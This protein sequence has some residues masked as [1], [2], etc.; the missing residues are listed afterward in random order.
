M[1]YLLLQSDARR[2]PMADRS[3]DLVLGSPPYCDARSYGIG[4]QRDCQAWVDWM[5]D[6]TTEA[7]RV[8]RNCVVWVAAGV[9]RDRNYWPACEGLMWEWWK[10][11]GSAYRPCYWT[12]KGIPGSGGDQ[13]FRADVE[14]CMCFKRSGQL[15]WSDNTAM[16]SMPKFAVGGRMSNRTKNGKRCKVV[17]M[18][19]E[20]QR[21]G[22][23]QNFTQPEIANPGNVVHTGVTGGGHLGSNYGHESEAPFPED[24]P[25]WFIRSLCRPGGI[26]LDPFSGSGTTVSVAT[27][28]GRIGI[29]GDIRLSQAELARRRIERPHQPAKKRDKPLPLFDALE[30]QP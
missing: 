19:G 18:G 27:R 22:E 4:A 24:I 11:G 1:T 25:E 15:D 14:Y 6:V 30:A 8:V 28:L 5:L 16:G 12:K 3:V 7:L 17:T 21:K 23:V 26:V 10:Q 13:W 9:T 2:I 29:G 20:R